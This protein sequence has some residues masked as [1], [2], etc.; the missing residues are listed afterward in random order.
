MFAL[1]L[2]FKINFL[3]S[4]NFFSLSTFS[5]ELLEAESRLGFSE[6]NLI[7][8]VVF[9]LINSLLLDSILLFFLSE[10]SFNFGVNS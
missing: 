6:A 4:S 8:S 10:F 2:T 1:V 3:F 5:A 9:S 7:T